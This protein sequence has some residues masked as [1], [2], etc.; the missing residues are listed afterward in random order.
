MVEAKKTERELELE[1]ALEDERA[2][3]KKDQTRLCELEDECHQLKKIPREK[4]KRKP[5]SGPMTR[6]FGWEDD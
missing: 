5:A 2:G 6:F 3:R 4:S 1:A